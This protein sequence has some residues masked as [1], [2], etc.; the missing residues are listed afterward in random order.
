MTLVR[1]VARLIAADLL[2]AALTGCG[3][4][5]CVGRGG[6]GGYAAGCGAGARF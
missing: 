5:G 4:F 2:G 6:N 1:M 3:V